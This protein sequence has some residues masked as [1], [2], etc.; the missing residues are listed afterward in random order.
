MRHFLFASDSFKGSLSSA[1][2]A[3]ILEAEAVKVFPGAECAALP[4]A[5]GGEGTV[6]SVL[7][8]CGGERV[9]AAVE[10]PLGDAVNA[11][12]GIL[13]DGRCVIELRTVN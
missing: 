10:G 9:C 5:D 11:S 4:I 7:S 8:A 6:D 2:I 3:R 12:Y 13:P 1:Q